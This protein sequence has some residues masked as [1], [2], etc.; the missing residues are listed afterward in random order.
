MKG[1]K[2]PRSAIADCVNLASSLKENIDDFKLAIRKNRPELKKAGLEDIKLLK[3]IFA[4][5]DDILED[6]SNI[7]TGEIAIKEWDYLFPQMIQSLIDIDHFMKNQFPTVY[8]FNAARDLPAYIGFQRS[9]ERIKKLASG[10]QIPI[11][12][13]TKSES[14]II[15]RIKSAVSIAPSILPFG[16]PGGCKHY[17]PKGGIGNM[18][19]E[20]KMLYFGGKYKVNGRYLE[21]FCRGDTDGYPESPGETDP[22]WIIFIGNAFANPGQWN[23]CPL[24]GSCPD[25]LYWW[26]NLLWMKIPVIESTQVTQDGHP[27]TTNG[28]CGRDFLLYY[29]DV[30]ERTSWSNQVTVKFYPD[31][32]DYEGTDT[33]RSGGGDG[34]GREEDTW[35]KITFASAEINTSQGNQYLSLSDPTGVEHSVAAG[36]SFNLLSASRVI[37]DGSVCSNDTSWH[38]YQTPRYYYVFIERDWITISDEVEVY[39]DMT[40]PDPAPHE[41]GLRYD[42]SSKKLLAPDREQ[43][44]PA[45]P[46]TSITCPADINN[47]GVVNVD[48]LLQL[49]MSWGDKGGPADINDDGIVGVSDLLQLINSWGPCPVANYPYKLTALD[50]ASND[51]FGKSVSI[52]GD[53]VIVGAP[54][55]YYDSPYTGPG[56]AYVF[57]FDGSQ[58]NQESKLLASDGANGALFG[59]SVS[60]SGDT[61]LVGAHKDDDNGTNSGSAYV[62]RFDGTQWVEE[63]KLLAS[64]GGSSDWFGWSVSISGDMAVV[65]ATRSDQYGSAYVFR[66]NGTQ[67]I[68]EAKLNAS[69]VSSNERFGEQVSISGDRVLIG[70]MWDD[71]NGYKAG[72]SYVFRFVGGE[73]IEES[74][75]LPSEVEENDWF[76]QGASI[77]GE[78]AIVGAHGDSDN[79]TYAGAAYVFHFDG[80]Q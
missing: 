31:F 3:Q 7:Y 67:W 49:I 50:G 76:G 4:K 68:E 20:E 41:R 27:N 6:F 17:A 44:S 8:G 63:Q 79:G 53:K 33:F 25:V 38:G 2:T 54:W 56:S 22:G 5:L 46:R 60:I 35:V 14:E 75:L 18:T 39:R 71:E 1:L 34:G 13:T 72:S 24:P 64:D 37:R 32:S 23:C 78:R 40:P 11:P 59:W 19:L 16:H 51:Q 61:A 36:R 58:W 12:P 65:G 62:F 21:P 47:D 73:W 42:E 77:S 66:F 28:G 45:E 57:R 9:I 74:K 48:D 10:Q 30:A 43:G 26:E 55:Q 52:E 70:A 29:Q 69:G 80:T 15:N